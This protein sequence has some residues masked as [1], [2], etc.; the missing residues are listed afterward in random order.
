MDSK[1]T[2]MIAVLV[3]ALP[4]A[5]LTLC[6]SDNDEQNGGSAGEE[7]DN[8]V[9]LSMLKGG[10]DKATMLDDTYIGEDNN[11]QSAYSVVELALETNAN[12][13]SGITNIPKSGWAEKVAVRKGYG[14]VC[15]KY[16]HHYNSEY[17]IEVEEGKNIIC[18]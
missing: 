4:M 14:Y 5:A 13:L 9:G 12:K 16:N 6:N 8:E 15:C 18:I 1:K 7:I 11:F 3:A 10:E 2:F 17:Y